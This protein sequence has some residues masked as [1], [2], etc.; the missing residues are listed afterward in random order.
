ML[1]V[2]KLYRKTALD[3]IMFGFI[4]GMKKALPSMTV[5]DCI[6]MFQKENDLSEDEFPLHSARVT[7]QRMQ[8]ESWANCKSEK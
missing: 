6:L 3:M 8:N 1:S 5:K 2:P 7:Y 4:N